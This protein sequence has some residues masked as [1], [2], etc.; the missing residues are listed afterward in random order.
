M[1]RV[2]QK[3]F[4]SGFTLIEFVIVIVVLGVMAAY[5]TFDA[6]PAELSIPSQAQTLASNIR[7]LQATAN[8][9]KRTRLT[10]TTGTPGSYAGAVCADANCTTTTAAFG[11][12][13]LDK[14]VALAGS[15]ATLY[16]DSLG[17]PGTSATGYTAT[18]ASY[19]VGGEKTVAVAQI[20][21]H[22]TVTP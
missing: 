17:R 13:T 12:V 3:L 5:V 11:A 19:T 6:S 9:G 1:L 15:P 21:G 18:S 2:H 14:G 7:H 4:S 8:A 16:F 10:V 20:T 22:V